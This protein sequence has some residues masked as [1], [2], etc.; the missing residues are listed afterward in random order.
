M[1]LSKTKEHFRYH[2]HL[3]AKAFA[4]LNG[5]AGFFQLQEMHIESIYR[6]LANNFRFV[7]L[8]FFS[9]VDG[10]KTESSVISPKTI[11]QSD[12]QILWV[13]LSSHFHLFSASM[14]TFYRSFTARN[15]QRERERV[16]ERKFLFAIG[17]KRFSLW[18]FSF[19][20][21]DWQSNGFQSWIEYTLLHNLMKTPWKWNGIKTKSGDTFK[22][23][24][25][26]LNLTLSRCPRHLSG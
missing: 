9:L 4:I 18:F 13:F 24:I 15:G 20:K 1:K 5:M 16:K 17:I 23:K 12:L 22:G 14:S 10:T 25:T 19:F 2:N 6:R 8:F 7:C 26:A 21:L 3:Y 11:H